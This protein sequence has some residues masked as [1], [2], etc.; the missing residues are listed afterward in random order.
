MPPVQGRCAAAIGI[1]GVLVL[2][3]AGAVTA[4][5]D[6][7]FP[8]DSLVEGIQQ[9]FSAASHFIVRLRVW[10]PVIATV[11]G[12]YLIQF[13]FSLASDGRSAW[14]AGEEVIPAYNATGL[15]NAAIFSLEDGDTDSAML[16]IER[17]LSVMAAGPGKDMMNDAK[18]QLEAGD[19]AG[20]LETLTTLRDQW[21]I[22]DPVNGTALYA[23][24]C[25]ACHGANGEGGVGSQLQPNAFVQ[26]NTT[27]DLVAFIQEGREGTTMAG[28]ETRLTEQEIADIVAHLR[29]WQ[30]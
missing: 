7:L 5:G 28:F 6:T 30:P 11:V 25:V 13:A 22:G 1:V 10:H 23:P 16:Q 26:M 17:A 8:V 27:A 4:L 12:L 18:A 29:T 3:M 2:S 15:I 24:N 14:K 19:I 21:P 9:D 20:A